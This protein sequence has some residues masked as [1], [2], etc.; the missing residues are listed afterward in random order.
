[1][2]PIWIGI[3]LP[4]EDQ[5][6]QRRQVKLDSQEQLG[7]WRRFFTSAIGSPDQSRE[8]GILSALRD[9]STQKPLRQLYVV[10]Y[11]FSKYG[12]AEQ[13]ARQRSRQV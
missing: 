4:R 9:L 8:K 6:C 1:M 11:W 13:L 10:M 2:S 3:L 5:P 7:T 12:F